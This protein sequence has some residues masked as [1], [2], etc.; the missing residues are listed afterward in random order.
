MKGKVLVTGGTGYIGSHTVIDLLD[1]G[2]EVVSI[3]NYL[4]SSSESLKNIEV[5]TG[6]VVKN[7][8]VDLIDLPATRHVFEQNPDLVGIIHFAAL[9]SVGESVEKPWD[10]FNNNLNSLL[11]ILK[12]AE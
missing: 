4:N 3:D 1:N 12:C 5:I 10:Y 11:N 8:E 2:F 6:K 9:K 7:Y